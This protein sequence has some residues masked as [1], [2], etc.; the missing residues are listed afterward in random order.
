MNLRLDWCSHEAAKYAVEHWHYSG[1]MP[2]PPIIKIGVWE[3]EKYIGAV[4]FSR[5]ASSNLYNPYGIT[6][7]QGCE[8]TRV[9]FSSIGGVSNLLITVSTL[10]ACIVEIDA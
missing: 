6:Q 7:Y 3:N 5:G 9:A 2:V 10:S 4:L 1:T 8:L